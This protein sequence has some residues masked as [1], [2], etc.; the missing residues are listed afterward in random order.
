LMTLFINY[1]NHSPRWY[2]NG[3]SPNEIKEL[4]QN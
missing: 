4:N 3:Y 2:L 1:S